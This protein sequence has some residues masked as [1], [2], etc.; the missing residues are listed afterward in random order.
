MDNLSWLFNEIPGGEGF[1]KIYFVWKSEK[2]NCQGKRI[3]ELA[4]GK[5]RETLALGQ[6][7]QTSAVKVRLF[8]IL[9]SKHLES[10]AA[11]PDLPLLH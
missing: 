1:N 3:K 9:F 5:V 7:F 8:T 6:L 11:H 10:L 4:E 2:G